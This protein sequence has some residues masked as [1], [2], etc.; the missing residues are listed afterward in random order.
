[1]IGE[2]GSAPHAPVEEAGELS[3]NGMETRD[4]RSKHMKSPQKKGSGMKHRIGSACVLLLVS[5]AIALAAQDPSPISTDDKAQ[6]EARIRAQETGQ[7]PQVQSAPQQPGAQPAIPTL[8]ESPL[9]LLRR[10]E[11]GSN[12]EYQLG[13]GDEITVNFAGRP[14]MQAK[15][16][17]GPDGRISLP[18]AGDIMVAGLTRPQ[19]AAAIETALSSYYTNLSV[20]VIVTKYTANRVVLLGAVDHPG[21]FTFDGTPSLLEVLARGGVQ[22]GPNKSGT[23]SDV[24]Q[25]PERCAIYRGTDQVVWVELRQMMETGNAL[26]D[27]RLRRD[28]VVYVPSSSERFISVLGEVQHPGAIPLAYNSTAASLLAQAGGVS[29]HAGSNPRIQIVD[30]TS[31]T[32]HYYTLKE[33]LDPIKSRE[34]TLKPGQIIFVPKSGFYRATYVLERLS[35]LIS[36]MTMAAYA[37]VL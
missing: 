8:K 3:P 19:A 29:D 9:E 12:E 35:P 27:L 34:V 20:Q 6:I 13:R 23:T 33:L 7:Q 5:S 22:A 21:M 15:P 25:I 14:E 26:A 36:V 18:L 16:I 28:D 31:G 24:N 4:N 30:P 37:G 1:M 10:F 11:P 17:V 32:S 2:I